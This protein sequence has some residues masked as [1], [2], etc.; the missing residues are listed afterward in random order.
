MS[1]ERTPKAKTIP[2]DPTKLQNVRTSTPGPKRTYINVRYDKK[3][4]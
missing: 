1:Y 2:P 3:E 4:E